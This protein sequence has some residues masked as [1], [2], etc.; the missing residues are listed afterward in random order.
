MFGRSEPVSKP[1]VT[2]QKREIKSYEVEP[3]VSLEDGQYQI[4]IS[5]GNVKIREWCSRSSMYTARGF[6]EYGSNKLPAELLRA[7]LDAWDEV[8]DT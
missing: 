1:K 2:K 8:K 5:Q 6:Y 3:Q 4:E 7:A